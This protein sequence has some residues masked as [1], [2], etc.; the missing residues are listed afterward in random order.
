MAAKILV[1]A[2]LA[3]S[4]LGNFYWGPCPSSHPMDT[5]DTSKYVGVW[6][7]IGRTK[8]VPYKATD[9][10]GSARYTARD[11]GYIGVLNQCEGEDGELM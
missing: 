3:C 6:Y 9:R 2:I 1:L 11:D 8:N 4:V 10:C 5:L 7:E